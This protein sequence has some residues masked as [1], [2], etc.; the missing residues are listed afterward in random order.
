LYDISQDELD[1][2]R[3]F[4]PEWSKNSTL[5]PI[6]DDDGDLRYIDFSHSNAYDVIARPL[7]TLLNNIQDGQANDKQLLASF[8]NGVNEAG[9]EIMNPFISESIWTEA[10]GD[11]TVRGG[12]TKDGRRLYTDQTSAGDKAAIR[13][14]H[15]GNALAPSYKQFVRLA[16]AATETPDA[17]GNVLDVGPEIAGFM[18]LRPIKVD[19][20]KSMGFKI[21]SYQRG[22]RDARREF[23][24]GY[25]G[26]LKGGSVDP[27]DIILRY[28]KSN[29][30]K[31]DVQQNMYNDLN[32][33]ETLG[34]GTNDLRRQFDERQIS[35]EDY[36]NLRR[37]RFDPYVPSGE[38]ANKF[39]D[40]ANNLGEDNP[41]REALPEL[42]AIRR[43]LRQLELGEPFN[44]DPLEFLI[45][46]APPTPPL[47]TSVTSAMPN[48]KTI[49]Q[50]QNILN[51]TQMASANAGGLTPLEEALLSSEEKQIR[52]RSRGI[53]T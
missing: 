52:L 27:N 49:T 24:G 46:P 29:K 13:F 11:L 23:T 34:I 42:N 37:G 48:N 2:L 18:G 33:A 22:I 12:V 25:F 41:F 53:T 36:N 50:G 20:L 3:R 40:I 6:R 8:V 5:I 15:L 35:N 14:L 38:I 7:R 43:E 44:I 19:P 30:A 4:V 9:A 10:A 31:F 47:P 32:A 17:R 51:Q 28:I 26:L 21:S 45:P 39:R 16:Q 1:A